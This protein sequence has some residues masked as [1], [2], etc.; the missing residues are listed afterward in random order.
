MDITRDITL[1]GTCFRD[2]EP[3]DTFFESANDNDADLYMKI[4]PIPDPQSDTPW[5]AVRLSDGTLNG[6]NEFDDTRVY[7]VESKV[8]ITDAPL[9]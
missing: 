9:P 8:V 3:G 5:N 7:R 4:E 2:L 1:T 6:W